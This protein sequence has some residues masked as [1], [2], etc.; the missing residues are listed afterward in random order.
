MP[1][2]FAM[3]G[4]YLS[5]LAELSQVWASCF[6]AF[7]VFWIG[8][9]QFGMAQTESIS[10]CLHIRSEVRVM[11][12]VPFLLLIVLCVFMAGCGAK[13]ASTYTVTGRIT[14]ADSPGQG[15]EGVTIDFTGWH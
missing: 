2:P 8:W 12:R 14:K 15:L 11:R 7:T 13:P 9:V 10:S 5:P 6:T 3:P 1:S 4:R